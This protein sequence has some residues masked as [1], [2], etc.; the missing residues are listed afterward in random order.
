MQI[1][2]VI[3]YIVSY[4]YGEKNCVCLLS[5][6]SDKLG[7]ITLKAVV[8]TVNKNIIQIMYYIVVHVTMYNNR[9]VVTLHKSLHNNEEINFKNMG[10]FQLEFVS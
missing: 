10:G 4:H 1:C 2:F 6:V 7:L 8:G 5:Q 3:L 9:Y